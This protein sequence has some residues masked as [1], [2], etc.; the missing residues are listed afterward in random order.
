LI[1]ICNCYNL[2]IHEIEN[3]S[4]RDIYDSIVTK[5]P[6]TRLVPVS[7]FS[8]EHIMWKNIH[9][10]VLPNYLKTFDYKLIWNL[11]P[12]KAKPYIAIYHGSKLCS[13]CNHADEAVNH[14]F[15]AVEK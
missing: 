8:I 13:F 1:D 14:M 9:H 12:L 5:R 4:I 15:F 3:K 2:E 11:L 10:A 7:H 6:I